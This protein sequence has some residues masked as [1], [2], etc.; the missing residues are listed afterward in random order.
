MIALFHFIRL[1]L[2]NLRRGGQR[3]LVALLCIAF[4]VMALVAMS[5]LAKSIESAVVL[6]PAQ[7][8]GGDLSI[9]R[10]AEDYPAPRGRGSTKDPPAE[11]RDQRLHPD[12][13]Q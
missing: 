12:C 10:Q 9:G 1:A 4:G 6:T 8:L 13:L 11:R 7:R 5:M 3:I 2:H